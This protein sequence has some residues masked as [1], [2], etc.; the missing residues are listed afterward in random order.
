MLKK[1]IVWGVVAAAI[2]VAV[3]SSEAPGAQAIRVSNASTLML[4]ITEANG[5][6]WAAGGTLGSGQLNI[7]SFTT[8]GAS[9]TFTFTAVAMPG[10]PATGSKLI[11]DGVFN[12]RF[13]TP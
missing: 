9:G 8:T 7:T 13:I 12:V 6:A 11:T 1:L 2:V 10:T 4:T 5:M 3:Q